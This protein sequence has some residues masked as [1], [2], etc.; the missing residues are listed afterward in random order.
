MADSATVS[1]RISLSSFSPFP[2]IFH[3]D[4]DNLNWILLLTSFQFLTINLPITFIS[5][6]ERSRVMVDHHPAKRKSHATINDDYFKSR[7]TSSPSRASSSVGAGTSCTSKRPKCSR[8]LRSISPD[9]SSF[10]FKN[11]LAFSRPCPI[12]SPS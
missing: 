10:S 5:S 12:R 11:C 4:S 1:K 7:G 6:H 9:T 8:I 3:T 2:F